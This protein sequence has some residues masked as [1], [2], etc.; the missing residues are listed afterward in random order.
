M[1]LGKCLQF[2][3]LHCVTLLFHCP[4]L[5]DLPRSGL[6]RPGHEYRRR[7]R[8]AL[9]VGG[10]WRVSV[11]KKMQCTSFNDWI[12]EPNFYQHLTSDQFQSTSKRKKL[13]QFFSLFYLVINVGG[14]LLSIFLTPILRQ[15]VHCFGRDDCFPLAFALP[16]VPLFLAVLFFLIASALKYFSVCGNYHVNS[17][18]KTNNIL[19]TTLQCVCVSYWFY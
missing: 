10:F 1:E 8:Q 14:I 9:R 19:F 4:Q 5:D 3:S 12:N 7:R 13:A 15:D 17:P 2:H 11:K 16:V 6:G 18:P